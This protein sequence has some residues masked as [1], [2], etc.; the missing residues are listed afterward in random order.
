MELVIAL[1]AACMSLGTGAEASPSSTVVAIA[2]A[3]TA[4]AA[5]SLPAAPEGLPARGDRGSSSSVVACPSARPKPKRT[6]DDGPVAAADALAVA[7]EAAT[8]VAAVPVST[9]PPDDSSE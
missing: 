3:A 1:K 8:I 7:E 6:A 4:P 9:D 5:T 2:A